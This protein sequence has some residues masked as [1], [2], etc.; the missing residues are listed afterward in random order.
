[1]KPDP[2][3]D[4]LMLQ[5]LVDGE[6][7]NETIQQVLMGAKSAPDQWQEIALGF[8]ENQT[9]QSAFQSQ[10]GSPQRAAKTQLSNHALGSLESNPSFSPK[11]QPISTP[12]RSRNST[13]WWVMAASLLVAATI[14]YMASEIR[15]RTVPS[16]NTLV[17]NKAPQLDSQIAQPSPLA[18][19]SSPLLTPASLKPAYHLEVSNSNE[20]FKDLSVDDA[21]A[22]VPIYRVGS[23]QQLRQF[24]S[25]RRDEAAI[26]NEV[27]ARLLRAGYQIE[28]EIE[29]ISGQLSDGESFVVPVRTLRFVVGQ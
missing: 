14:G 21:N 20:K 8:V 27:L 6:L 2:K 17:E 29:L 16:S 12:S 9:W 19:K 25:K 26:P 15:G 24:Q 13:P 3:I 23:E 18:Q 5:R 28:Q 4:P 10:T 11:D 1:M 22:R 7:E